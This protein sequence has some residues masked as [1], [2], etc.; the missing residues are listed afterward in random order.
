MAS[1]LLS[2]LAEAPGPPEILALTFEFAANL[3]A[4][5]AVTAL[6][7]IAKHPDRASVQRDMRFAKLVF[8]LHALARRRGFRSRL[9]PRALAAVRK[10]G[11][12]VE[13]GS[14]L[15]S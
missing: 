10:L 9:L 8:D 15:Q 14:H 11:R 1:E 5:C 7:A 3:D 2:R 13:K 12:S 4:A 6:E